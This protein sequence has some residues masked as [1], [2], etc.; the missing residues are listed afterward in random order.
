MSVGEIHSSRWELAI[1]AWD[2]WTSTQRKWWVFRMFDTS[3][4]YIRTCLLQTK[5]LLDRCTPPATWLSNYNPLDHLGSD[6]RRECR[7]RRSYL[8]RHGEWKDMCL[9]SAS[10]LLWSRL[11]YYWNTMRIV[12]STWKAVSLQRQLV[13]SHPLSLHNLKRQRGTIFEEDIP[14][15]LDG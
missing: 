9:Y 12:S 3:L 2:S 7:W 8:E 13:S 14:Q 5:R 4:T 15:V 11:E 1:G 6:S 10:S